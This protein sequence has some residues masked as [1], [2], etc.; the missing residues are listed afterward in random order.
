MDGEV[1]YLAVGFADRPEGFAAPVDSADRRC[2][3]LFVF[4]G[5]QLPYGF[6]M[7]EY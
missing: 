7:F 5:L 6:G 2:W 4:P 1:S 3:G